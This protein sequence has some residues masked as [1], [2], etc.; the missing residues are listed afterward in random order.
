[1]T[2]KEIILLY[3]FLSLGKW[4]SIHTHIHTMYAIY[5]VYLK[6]VNVCFFIDKTYY[7]VYMSRIWVY[8]CVHTDKHLSVCVNDN[9]CLNGRILFTIFPPLTTLSLVM[10][11][12]RRIRI[13]IILAQIITIKYFKSIQRTIARISRRVSNPGV[14]IFASY[15]GDLED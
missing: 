1:M 8:T 6:I 12:V 14:R 5:F 7:C 15:T 3:T 9:M 10:T 11:S 13:N 2:K 4:F